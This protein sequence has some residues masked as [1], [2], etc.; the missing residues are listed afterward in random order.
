MAAL[1]IDFGTSHTVAAL[2]YG[3]GRVE[4][5]LFD[6]S[7][8][9]PS[10]VYADPGGRLLTG[11]DATRGGRLDPAGVEPNPKRRIDDGVLLLGDHEVPV[12]D[13]VASVLGRVAGEAAR[14]LGR[15]ADQTVL[16]HPAKWAAPRCAVLQAAA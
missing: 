1:G 3:S 12:V 7:P 14:A 5:L 13:A 16:T 4:P 11:A 6:A 8:L 2:R 15:P 9:L 10:A